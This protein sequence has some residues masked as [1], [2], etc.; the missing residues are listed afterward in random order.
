VLPTGLST[1]QF[2]AAFSHA[3]G[4][5]TESATATLSGNAL[6]VSPSR[7]W[8]AFSEVMPL[9]VYP[10]WTPQSTTP[11]AYQT[12][13]PPYQYTYEAEDYFTSV[14][15]SSGS[16]AT[17][18][19]SFDKS[20]TG[21]YGTDLSGAQSGDS[22]TYT[23]YVPTTGNQTFSI[24][25]KTGKTHGIFSI[26]KDGYSIACPNDSN[27]NSQCDTYSATN[28]YRLINVETKDFTTG[29]FTITLTVT[30]KNGSSTGYDLVIDNFS[31]VPQS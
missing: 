30:G 16:T 8:N 20:L 14:N 21:D 25:V 15:L 10:V 17:E 23:L 18:I 7:T 29:A 9:S 2:Q 26:A 22:M 12:N 1:T 4:S 11:P 19:D 28:G 6:Q 27:G 24:R 13:L 5:A 3:N 31:F